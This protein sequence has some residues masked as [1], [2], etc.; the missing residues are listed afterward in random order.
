MPLGRPRSALIHVRREPLWD[1]VQSTCE[2]GLRRRAVPGR[3]L[4]PIPRWC[5]GQILPA[6]F[7]R[8]VHLP[9]TDSCRRRRAS[10]VLPDQVHGSNPC[11]VAL[12]ART[13]LVPADRN[14]YP[15]ECKVIHHLGY[16]TFAEEIA[17]PKRVRAVS[18]SCLRVVRLRVE[19]NTPR[20]RR[21]SPRAHRKRRVT[22]P[23]RVR[24]TS[25]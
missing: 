16:C 7:P 4:L 11:R 5:R 18:N 21:R 6:R 25:L 9:H 20:P 10:G 8:R 24:V 17:S 19:P 2:L 22:L 13:K 12:S 14:A 3:Q 15:R 1:I 23:S